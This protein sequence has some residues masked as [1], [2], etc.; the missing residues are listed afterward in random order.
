MAKQFP[1]LNHLIREAAPILAQWPVD[2]APLLANPQWAQ[3][4]DGHVEEI[5]GDFLGMCFGMIGRLHTL[6]TAARSRCRV[7]EKGTTCAH[8]FA[9]TELENEMSGTL[10]KSLA[11]LRRWLQEND[12]P[13]SPLVSRARRPRR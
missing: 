1:R 5:T 2:L 10:A 9:E 6:G 12:G 3:L 7:C 11:V 4:R 8:C 13:A